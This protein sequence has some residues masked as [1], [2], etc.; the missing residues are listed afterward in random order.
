MIRFLICFGIGLA[1][2][3]S[4]S[5]FHAQ[6]PLFLLLLMGSIG[7]LFC[8]FAQGSLK[9]YTGILR[10]RKSEPVPANISVLAM[11]P[12]RGPGHSRHR[13]ATLCAEIKMGQEI[14]RGG[15]RGRPHEHALAGQSFQGWAWVDP[16]TRA[17]LELKVQ[18]RIITPLPIVVQAGP[19]SKYE[20]WLNQ[21]QSFADSNTPSSLSDDN[22]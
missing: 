20:K 16:Q 7:V 21:L 4:V 3:T 12:P 9:H 10:A 18:D 5:L 1:L 17:P 22:N 19:G 8:F 11:Q 6:I 2:L 13:P 15:L 14:W